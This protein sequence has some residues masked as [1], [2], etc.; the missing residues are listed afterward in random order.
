MARLSR[1]VQ[2]ASAAG[3]LVA[4][5]ALSACGNG[6]AISQAKI[7]CDRIDH[8]IRDLQRAT[9]KE[10]TP[11]GAILK[12]KAQSELLS[13]LAPAAAATSADGSF[14]ALMTTISEAGRVPEALLVDALAAQC[15]VVKSNTPYLAS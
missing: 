15:K 2:V 3:A 11:E 6:A 7:A 8:S 1:R 4:G 9:A 10:G 5:I 13:A 12:A 14:N